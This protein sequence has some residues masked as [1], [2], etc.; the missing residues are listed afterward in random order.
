[1]IFTHSLTDLH[2]PPD[3]LITH[4]IV[5]LRIKR[6][7]SE[8]NNG[9]LC[10]FGS[11]RKLARPIN[12]NRSSVDFFPHIDGAAIKT[13]RPIK[14]PNTVW[15]ISNV[16]VTEY[17]FKIIQ[18]RTLQALIKHDQCCIEYCILTG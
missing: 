1:M 8:Q 7:L 2:I 11:V 6:I 10:N 16:Q 3:I 14:F 17:S 18:Q 9:N 4:G 12:N 15:Q 5:Q 13:M